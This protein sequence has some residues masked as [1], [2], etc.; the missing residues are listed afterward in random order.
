M[1]VLFNIRSSHRLFQVSSGVYDFD[2]MDYTI[3]VLRKCKEYGFRVYMDPHQDIVSRHC[4]CLEHL[5]S[6]FISPETPWPVPIRRAISSQSAPS[7]TC[8]LLTCY[9]FTSRFACLKT[10]LSSPT[11]S[12]LDI[13]V[14]PERPNVHSRLAA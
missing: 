13:A 4:K 9:P 12:G 5:Q 2:F 10:N 8:G 1:K 11:S 6:F 14:A 3:R 7:P